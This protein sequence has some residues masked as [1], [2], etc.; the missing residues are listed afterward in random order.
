MRTVKLEPDTRVR[1]QCLEVKDGAG[2]QG[3]EGCVGIREDGNALA[4]ADLD[5]PEVEVRD[6]GVI[7]AAEDF[8]GGVLIACDSSRGD[9]GG[10]VVG[11][12]GGVAGR[13]LD[14]GLESKGPA[15]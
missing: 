10:D 12:G 3:E 1:G 4:A 13:D 9:A 6:Q 14:V 15:D 8:I 5:D 7:E 11:P 2:V